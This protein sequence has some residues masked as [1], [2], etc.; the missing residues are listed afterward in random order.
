MNKLLFER[1]EGKSREND[2]KPT[3]EN[4]KLWSDIWFQNVKHNENA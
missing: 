3:A 2:V 1:I 4:R